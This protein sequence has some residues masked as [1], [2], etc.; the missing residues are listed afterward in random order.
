MFLD[1]LAPQKTNSNLKVQSKPIRKEYAAGFK[2]YHPPQSKQSSQ[3]ST[4]TYEEDLFDQL[5]IGN[6]K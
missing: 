2:N 1:E 4:E 6:L 3:I 5:K